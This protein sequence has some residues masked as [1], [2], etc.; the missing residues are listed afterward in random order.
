[1]RGNKSACDVGVCVRMDDDTG[2]DTEQEAAGPSKTARPCALPFRPPTG[3]L[4]GLRP[5]TAGH[6]QAWDA[7]SLPGPLPSPQLAWA[8]RAAWL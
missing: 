5:L 6:R 2:E 1:M 7:A 8:S 4:P 3:L